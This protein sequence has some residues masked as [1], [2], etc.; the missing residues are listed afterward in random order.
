MDRKKYA[1]IMAGG[2]GLRMGAAV[3]KQFLELGGKPILRL[4]V[5]RFLEYDPSIGLVIVLPASGKEMWK[6]YC[7]STGFLERY[8]MAT[9]GI[10]RFHSVQNAL[11]YVPDGALVAV[12]DGVRPFVTKKFLARMFD[13]ARRC[14]A[15]IPV[16]TAIDS[17]REVEPS[18]SSFPIDRSKVVAVQTPQVFRSEILKS[19]Y[20]QAYSTSFTDDASVVEAAGFRITLCEGLRGNFKITTPEDFEIAS[21]LCR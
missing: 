2:E 13:A 1:V 20:T 14:E 12:H 8:S 15:V 7:A 11:K 18:G 9:G 19:A 4:T 21:A 16:I 5:E 10:T 3:P 6:E 17:L